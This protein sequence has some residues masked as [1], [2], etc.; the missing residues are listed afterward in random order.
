MIVVLKVKFLSLVLALKVAIKF[1]A[2]R[3]KSNF[4]NKCTFVTVLMIER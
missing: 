4:V 1:L 3:I 2:M